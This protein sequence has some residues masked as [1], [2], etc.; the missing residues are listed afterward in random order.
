MIGRALFFLLASASVRPAGAGGLDP[1]VAARYAVVPDVEDWRPRLYKE[2]DFDGVEKFVA[3]H[4]KSFDDK[5]SDE[6][7]RFYESLATI[8]EAEVPASTMK[9]VLDEWTRTRP[10]S[11]A[12]RMALGHFH[13]HLAWRARGTGWGSDVMPGQRRVFKEKLES[14]QVDLEKAYAMDPKDPNSAD[15]L[16]NL[17]RAR[18]LPREKME[19]YYRQALAAD[20]GHRG[21]R[22]NKLEFITPRWFGSEEEVEAFGRECLKDSVK[23]PYAGRVAIDVLEERESWA[24][25]RA[26]RE[27]RPAAEV[28]KPNERWLT[29]QIVYEGILAHDPGDLHI[30]SRYAYWAHRLKKYREAAAQFDAIGDRWIRGTSW[31]SLAD[32]NQARAATYAA[33]AYAL[34][35]AKQ[36]EKAKPWLD[37]MLTYEP[38]SAWGLT[39]MAM[40]WQA[41]GDADKAV[42][43]AEKSLARHPNPGSGEFQWATFILQ[44]GGRPVGRPAGG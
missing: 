39:H 22:A 9:A 32:Y 6:L 8:D 41:A 13:L 19:D 23:Y 28:F 12:A 38:D 10:Q 44:V 11:H 24:G 18:G 33:L 27:H 30:R 42:D 25:I 34:V 43:F 14:A 2:K 40:Y 26:R 35:Q 31:N 1:A 15:L 20:P 16:V 5:G 37:K 36:W 4:L 17:S 29:T 3:D 7:T 21:A